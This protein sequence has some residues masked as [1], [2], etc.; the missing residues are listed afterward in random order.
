MRH[1]VGIYKGRERWSDE[2]GSLT[3]QDLFEA[4]P[5]SGEVVAEGVPRP[6]TPEEMP[7]RIRRAVSYLQAEKRKFWDPGYSHWCASMRIDHPRD[8]EKVCKVASLHAERW[9]NEGTGEE[10]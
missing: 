3:A 10:I 6:T 2:I 9:T 1:E 5:P 8:M 4:G 7:G